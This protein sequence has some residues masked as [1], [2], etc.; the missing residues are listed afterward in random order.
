MMMMMMMHVPLLLSF[1]MFVSALQSSSDSILLN[2]P[3]TKRCVLWLHKRH[4]PWKHLTLLRRRHSAAVIFVGS[5]RTAD[6]IVP[7]THAAKI[8]RKLNTGWATLLVD[9]TCCTFGRQFVGLATD[10][11]VACAVS[12]LL[13]WY[14][15]KLIELKLDRNATFDWIHITVHLHAIT[16][17]LFCLYN[18][19]W[20]HLVGTVYCICVVSYT[21]LRLPSANYCEIFYYSKNSRPCLRITVS[22]VFFQISAVYPT[23]CLHSLSLQ[24]HNGAAGFKV[25][26][27][28]RMSIPTRWAT[29]TSI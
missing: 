12:P 8:E 28:T 20:H 21:S 7:S 19:C 29:T 27:M 14:V 18:S 26:W 22:Q 15:L 3:C 1:V 13:A 6:R 17:M 11:P 9:E 2:T 10:A 24:H 25:G 23:L 5:E 16:V 4:A